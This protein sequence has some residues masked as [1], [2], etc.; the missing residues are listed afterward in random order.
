M[1]AKP[2]WSGLCFESVGLGCGV[3]L[4]ASGLLLN[5]KHLGGLPG[6][7]WRDSSDGDYSGWRGWG[8]VDRL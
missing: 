4:G 8:C 6:K 1:D 5:V 7:N 2:F 3:V